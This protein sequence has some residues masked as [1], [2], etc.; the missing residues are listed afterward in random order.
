MSFVMPGYTFPRVKSIDRQDRICPDLPN[1]PFIVL[2]NFSRT[3]VWRGLL[4]PAVG[5]WFTKLLDPIIIILFAES[6]VMRSR[7]NMCYSRVFTANWNQPAD[8]CVLIVI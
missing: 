1:R 7:L 2:S 8:I 5:I 6:A 3:T 4:I